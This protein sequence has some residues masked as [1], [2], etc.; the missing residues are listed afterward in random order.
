MHRL[1]LL[2]LLAPLSLAF[3]QQDAGA[4][5]DKA[6]LNVDRA[7]RARIAEFYS[8]HVN[9]EFTKALAL[10]AADSKEYFIAGGNPRLISFEIERIR[11][12]EKFTH[13][14]VTI[15][16]ER[17]VL[18]PG[19]GDVMKLPMVSEW[20]LEKGKWCWWADPAKR[21]MT[22]FSDHQATAG[23]MAKAGAPNLAN[24][25]VSLPDVLAKVEADKT[26]MSLKPGETGSFTIGNAMPGPVTPRVIR[27]PKGVD[28]ALSD[29][30]IAAQSRVTVTLT[31]GAVAE[32]GDLIVGIDELGK[33]ITVHVAIAR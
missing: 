15:R 11:Y 13:A 6:P 32:A 30:K 1:T 23:P 28:V 24:I 19:F 2:A 22:P 26:T 18:L 14:V 3:G 5:F 17:T 16:A 27:K 8:Y 31:A 4:L 33:A 25:P 7:L 21:N 12:G 9:G 20:K 29:A 10:V